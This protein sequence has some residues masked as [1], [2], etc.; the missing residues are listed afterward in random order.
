VLDAEPPLS[1]GSYAADGSFV[2]TSAPLLPLQPSPSGDARY[3]QFGR[4][5]FVSVDVKL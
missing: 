1:G 5:Y 4:R 2:S 3:D